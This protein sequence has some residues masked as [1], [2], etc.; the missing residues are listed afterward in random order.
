MVRMLVLTCY[1][2]KQ[3]KPGDECKIDSATEQRWL[4]NGIAKRI[5]AVDFDEDDKSLNN[6]LFDKQPNPSKFDAMSDEEVL[7]YAAQIGVDI[8]RVQSRKAAIAKI[9]KAEQN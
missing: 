4:K 6:D 5:E 7:E 2:G 9:L 1:N 3:Y 8:S